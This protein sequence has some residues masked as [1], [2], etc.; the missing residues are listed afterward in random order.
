[1]NL[2][3]GWNPAHFGQ[4]FADVRAIV[5]HHTAGWPSRAKANGFVSRYTLARYG[6]N[7]AGQVVPCANCAPHPQPISVAGCE[8]KWGIGPQYYISSD[9]TI[10]R[11][12]SN[13]HDEARL[14]F[15]GGYT[16][17]WALGVETG[18]LFRVA[19]PPGNGW[20][21]VNQAPA[22]DD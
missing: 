10:A 5:P 1:M 13:R 20:V 14:T 18:S 15:H 16:N 2:S 21:R 3:A 12:I 8:C 19:A 6:E 7:A 11:L 17:G 9:G 22:H 4:V